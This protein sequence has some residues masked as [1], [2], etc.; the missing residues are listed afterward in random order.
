MAFVS[1]AVGCVAGR[2]QDVVQHTVSLMVCSST[3][4]GLKSLTVEGFTAL[5][6]VV[7]WP[8]AVS[9]NQAHLDRPAMIVRVMLLG[10][11]PSDGQRSQSAL[12]ERRTRSQSR[13]SKRLRESRAPVERPDLPQK[14]SGPLRRHSRTSIGADSLRRHPFAARHSSPP[15]RYGPRTMPQARNRRGR[16]PHRKRRMRIEWLASM[17]VRIRAA[18]R[19]DVQRPGGGRTHYQIPRT[20]RPVLV[21]FGLSGGRGEMLAAKRFYFTRRSEHVLRLVRPVFQQL[22]QTRQS[23]P[24]RFANDSQHHFP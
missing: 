7:V 16:P 19:T 21:P 3:P 17:V 15:S 11:W 22:S 24:T 10:A 1:N 13:R 5:T 9:S 12:R 4:Y 2:S 8:R 18:W 14:P 23:I 20:V 6:G